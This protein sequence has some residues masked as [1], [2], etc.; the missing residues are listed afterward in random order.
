MRILLIA[1]ALTLATA[2]SAPS[3]AQAQSLTREYP[4]MTPIPPNAVVTSA[5]VAPPLGSVALEDNMPGHRRFRP[6][7]FPRA[8][9]DSPL[10]PD[11]VKDYDRYLIEYWRAPFL[12]A[13]DQNANTAGQDQRGYVAPEPWIPRV[14]RSRATPEQDALFERRMQ[15]ITREILRAVPLRNLHGASVEPELTI[16]GYGQQHGA[17]GDGVMRGEIVLQFRQIMPSTGENQ[18]M[19]DGTIRSTYFGP[20]LRITLNPASIDCARPVD[21]AATGLRC[22]DTDARLVLATDRT[23]TT[24]SGTAAEP[25]RVLARDAFADGRP[26]TDIRALFVRHDRRNNAASEIDRG[27]MHPHDP[28][29][30]IIGAVN[31]LDWNG[32]LRRAGEV[33]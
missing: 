24:A 22:L 2:A 5:G 10:R 26:A 19:P 8:G 9:W 28:L 29:G 25:R 11:G 32:L 18:R 6:P 30:R 20:T 27:R 21:I 15:F 23:V 7:L 12:P 17:Q 31:L 4:V 1:A 3:S 16:Q 14:E 13:T 33:Q